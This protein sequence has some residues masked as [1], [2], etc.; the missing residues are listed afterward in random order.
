MDTGFSY[1]QQP[2]AKRGLPKFKVGKIKPQLFFKILVPVIIL[3][4]LSF[5][6]KALF[7]NSG[8]GGSV[9]SSSNGN[10]NIEVKQSLEKTPLN[11]EFK[12]PLSDAKGKKIGEFSYILESA[13]ITDEIIVQGKRAT[14]VKGRQFLIINLKLINTQNYGIEISTRDFVRLMTNGDTKQLFA[15]DIH[16][17]PVEA[18]AISTKYSRIG[19]PINE[20]DKNLVIQVGEINGPK[21]TIQLNLKK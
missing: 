6:I 2:R 18:Q 21:E 17:D 1:N 12:F 20:T 16:N 19:F 10:K 14:A 15:P 13:E 7:S 11:R 9:L 4:V 5:S 8:N 3:L